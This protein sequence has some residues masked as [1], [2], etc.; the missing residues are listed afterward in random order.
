MLEPLLEKLPDLIII[1]DKL[2]FDSAITLLEDFSNKYDELKPGDQLSKGV[3][4]LADRCSDKTSPVTGDARVQLDAAQAAFRQQEDNLSSLEFISGFLLL[5]LRERRTS[6]DPQT[7]KDIRY[8]GVKFFS[9]LGDRIG[10]RALENIN[11]FID[12]FVKCWSRKL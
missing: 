2:D 1:P 8:L 10:V 12:E 7:I 6:H 9:I 4:W 5:N 3:D 11:S